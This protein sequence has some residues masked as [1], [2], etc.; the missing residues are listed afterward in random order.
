MLPVT[1]Q[2]EDWALALMEYVFGQKASFTP[3]LIQFGNKGVLLH[4]PTGHPI[5]CEIMDALFEAGDLDPVFELIFWECS[6]PDEIKSA[7]KADVPHIPGGQ[8]VLSDRTTICV[9]QH[10]DGLYVLDRVKKRILIWVPRYE[11]FPF[12]AKATP[13]R[14]PFSW[15]ASENDGEMI[16]CAGIELDGHGILLAGNGGRGK[17]TT[18]IN[19]ALHGAKI[20]GE[21]FIL[22]MKDS[23]FA[24]YTKAKIHPGIHLDHLMGKGLQAPSAIPNQKTIVNLRNQPFS[25]VETFRPTILYFPGIPGLDT[26]TEIVRISKALALRE[27]AGPSFI[28]LQGAGAHSL[29]QHSKLVRTI[30]TWS[31]PMTG[32]LDLDIAKMKTHLRTEVKVE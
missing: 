19:A 16:H 5:S 30:D 22:Y 31:L 6:V 17:T 15:V 21:D 13:F 2:I 14:I 11:K 20:L 10:T 27:F 7:T 32:Q 12:W 3:H 9:D 24:V 26:A 29:E 1:S 25:M 18:A 4:L 8:H 23:V 28:G